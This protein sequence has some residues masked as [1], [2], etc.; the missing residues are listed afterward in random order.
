MPV[1]NDYPND[2]FVLQRTFECLLQ[3][4]DRLWR[5]I[6]CVYYRPTVLVGESPY[7]DPARRSG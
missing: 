4:P 2:W 3:T 5:Q 1:R 6:A 7:G